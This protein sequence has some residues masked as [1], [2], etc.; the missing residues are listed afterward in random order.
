VTVALCSD[1]GSGD[2]FDLSREVV[3]SLF[4]GGNP[5]LFPR[6]NTRLSLYHVPFKIVE[7][8][9][10][11]LLF[12]SFGLDAVRTSPRGF[13]ATTFHGVGELWI[14]FVFALFKVHFMPAPKQLPLPKM[15]PTEVRSRG[16]G[17]FFGFRTFR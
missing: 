12:F 17:P 1:G 14:N 3:L 4:V 6:Q 11:D 8:V 13:I 7:A 5:A 10:E 2:Y 9:T 15:T 16:A